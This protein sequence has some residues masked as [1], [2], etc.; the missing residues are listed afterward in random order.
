MANN[1]KINQ[2][3]EVEPA[4]KEWQGS[5]KTRVEDINGDVLNLG[6]PYVGGVL[7]PLKDGDTVTVRFADMVA[8][9]SFTADVIEIKHNP[10]PVF[11]IKYPAATKRIQ[12][13]AFVRLNVNLPMS[14]QQNNSVIETFTYDVGG[15]GLKMAAKSPVAVGELL[16]LKIDFKT[17]IVESYAEVV[18]VIEEETNKYVVSVRFIDLDNKTVDNILSWSF[19]YQLELRRKGLL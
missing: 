13:R 2:L 16:K 1:L 19:K 9:Y 17:F 10:V 14:Y 7:L 15:G 12:R 11:K 6:I 8:M 3:V 5:Y 4:R 18:R